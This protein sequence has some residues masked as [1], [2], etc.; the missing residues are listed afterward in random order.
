MGRSQGDKRRNIGAGKAPEGDDR[1]DEPDQI[2]EIVRLYGGYAQNAKSKI[3]DNADFGYTRVTV[4]RPLRLRYRMTVEDKARFLDAAP[5]LNR[6]MQ[7]GFLHLPY[8]PQQVAS[9][10]ARR[11]EEALPELHQQ[12]ELAS[13]SLELQVE[14]AEL[15]IAACLP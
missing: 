11:R 3:F 10:L 12:K 1:P 4:E 6:S 5:R 13:M 15:A 9:L 2:A 14:A 8:L 7:C